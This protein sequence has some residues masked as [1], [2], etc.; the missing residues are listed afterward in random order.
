ML[1]L[2]VRE[3]SLFVDL[4]FCPNLICREEMGSPW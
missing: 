1:G 2:E 4:S 3:R